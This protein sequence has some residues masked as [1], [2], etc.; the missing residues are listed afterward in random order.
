MKVILT[1]DCSNAAFDDT[2]CGDEIARILRDIA[3]SAE[4]G[5]RE[6]MLEHNGLVLFDSNGNSVGQLEATV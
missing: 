1:I 2:G 6:A 4:G 5:T 3:D